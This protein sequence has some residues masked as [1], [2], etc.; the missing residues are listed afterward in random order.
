MEVRIPVGAPSRKEV[1]VFTNRVRSHVIDLR[2]PPKKRWL[3][4]LDKEYEIM[5][6]IAEQAMKDM[7]E[8]TWL[9]KSPTVRML[10][11]GLYMASGGKYRAEM[12]SLAMG[13]PTSAVVALNCS[14]ELSH[15]SEA[16]LHRGMACTAG[17]K[18][19]L[20]GPVLVRNLDW[21]IQGVGR[22]TRIFIFRDG[23][24]EFITVGVL[25]YVGVLSGMVPGGWAATINW[26]PAMGKP[27]LRIGPTALLREALQTCDTYEQAKE[28]LC[29]T[30]LN[31][32]VFYT[33][34]GVRRGEGCVIERT[35]DEFGVREMKGVVTQANHHLIF[36]DNNDPI[37]EDLGP[38]YET[39]YTDSRMR[40][41]MLRRRLRAVKGSSL[42]LLARALDDDPV[43]N[44]E[45]RQQMA[46]HPR[47][48]AYR[49][50]RRY[51]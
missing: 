14:Y 40:S 13:F 44:D 41:G 31:T 8:V 23:D 6:E 3:H 49:V 1:S 18:G 29:R 10:I 46:F 33:L 38:E 12:K 5:V 48:G 16:F 21:S 43:T 27:K 15:T 17:V 51:Q 24:R 45:T 20:D 7:E 34:C 25:G 11:D 32:S 50:W 26:A 35:P 39:H 2:L 30:R 28:M 37:K 9:V 22:G 36:E 42:D 4:V 47:A 19:T